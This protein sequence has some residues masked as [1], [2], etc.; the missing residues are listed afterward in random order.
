M[1]IEI[2][3][4]EARVDTTKLLGDTSCDTAVDRTL[5]IDATA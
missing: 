2:S 1:C 3:V 4:L 5:R